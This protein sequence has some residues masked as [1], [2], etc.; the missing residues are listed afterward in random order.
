MRPLSLTMRGFC[1]FRDP[2][3]ISFRDM[4]VFVISGPTGAGKSTIIDAICYALYGR[5]PR[6]TDAGS[7]IAHGCDQMAVALEFM[8]GQE[9]FRVHRGITMARRTGRDGRERVSRSVSLPQ[10]EHHDGFEWEPLEG[11][12]REI[13]AEIE[14]IVGLDF[15]GFT[16]CVLLPQGQFQEFLTGDRANRNKIIENLLDLEVYGRMMQTANTG[17]RDLAKEVENLER[18]LVEDFADAT[19]DALK[20]C[21]EE[22]QEAEQRRK[23]ADAEQGALVAAGAAALSM[24]S[25]LNRQR[26]DERDH[27]A[28]VTELE[29]VVT[30]A[31]D[32]QAR[33][34]ELDRRSQTTQNEFDGIP[35]DHT[36]HQDLV[37]A[38]GLAKRV[39]E[40]ARK[41]HLAKKAAEDT[42]T[43]ES[44]QR[45]LGE[46][47]RQHA[48]DM[49]LMSG[50]QIEHDG[51]VHTH[52]A[53][54]L[55]KGLKPGELCPVCGRNVV[56]LP[57]LDAPNLEEL[58]ERLA[59]AKE[60]LRLTQAACSGASE[61]L[62]KAN[63]DHENAVKIAQESASELGREALA[64]RQLLPEAIEDSEEAVGARLE[65]EEDAY[66]RR[67]EL[68][69]ALLIIRQQ[70]DDLSGEL[71]AS[72]GKIA[73]LRGSLASLESS[74]R[75]AKEEAAEQKCILIGLARDRAWA[76]LASE[77]EADADIAVP[78]QRRRNE[79]D[80][81][82]TNLTRLIGGLQEKEER[83]RKDMVRAEELKA[84]V[85]QRQ[86]RER[87]FRNLGNLLRTDGFRRFVRE[88][89]M[90]ILS[91]AGSEHLQAM[92]PRFA[93]TVQSDEFQVVDHWQ[94]DEL[95]PASTL[96][97][98]ETF[99]ASLSLALALAEQLPALRSAAA[100]TL[101]S[102]FLDEG[103]GTL[104]PE[105]LDTVISAIES[106]RAQ[107]RLVGIITHV[108]ELANRIEYRIDVSKSPDGSSIKFVSA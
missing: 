68:A 27:N 94:A 82:L 72:A 107:E 75:R 64:L 104:D 101:E 108:P 71:S 32:G 106:L 86:D 100:T 20:H 48:A 23:E 83:I 95:R 73:S 29:Q 56:T 99:V 21:I 105:T 50:L 37:V 92:Y 39:A 77:L 36:L 102:L 85:K 51:A 74:I 40:L 97:G 88:E 14:R 3:E 7:L 45:D 34:E 80:M 5:G 17:A 15:Q 78:V 61:R 76:D 54:H 87:L 35:Y 91:A 30:L 12:V 60:A 63:S 8:A 46:A 93:L 47:D 84:D 59:E 79:V 62:V 65:V 2:V 43:V 6:G 31:H 42:G 16:R 70:R 41:A 1:C 28:K 9:H 10:L 33:L 52:A 55:Q 90:L 26:D 58:G 53:A 4:D 66:N 69:E 57:A 96:S 22:L 44:C 81:V 98:G 19:P 49:A 18:R 25:S 24:G 103:F 67:S 38:R 11:R 89:A 13:G